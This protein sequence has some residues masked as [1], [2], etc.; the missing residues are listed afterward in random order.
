[1]DRIS[2]TYRRRGTWRTLGPASVVLA[3]ALASGCAREA[4][5]AGEHY[6]QEESID[7][8]GTGKFYLDREIARIRPHREVASWLDRPERELAEFPERLVK[9]LELQPSDV[10]ADIGAGTG[11]YTFRIAENVPQGRVLAV[12]IQPEMLADLR[13][14]AEEEGFSNVQVIR[15]SEDDPNLPAATVD[16]VLIVGSCHEFYYPYE[17]MRGIEIALVPGGRLFLAEYRGEDDTLPLSPLHRISQE[18]ARKEM[19]YVG[20]EWERTLD[21]LPRQHLMIFRKPLQ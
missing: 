13:R 18:Q 4:D 14:K 6:R 16:V 9:A 12:D 21:I 8:L 17:M 19:E 1:M 20:L 2:N 7:S 5:P 15:G 10:V 3:V 11:Y